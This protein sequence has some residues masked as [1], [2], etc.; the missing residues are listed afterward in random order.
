MKYRICIILLLVLAGSTAP[1]LAA[2]EFRYSYITV[3]RMSIDLIKDD[4]YIRVD[5]TLDTPIKVLI[6]L[7]GTNDLKTKLTRMIN[8]EKITPLEVEMD[9]ARFSVEGEVIDYGDGAMW[10]PEH[11]FNAVTPLLSI[12]TPQGTVVYTDTS[13]LPKGTG[14][15]RAIS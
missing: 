7:L 6:Y 9:H 11:R 8:Y 10:L 1:V 15:F 12:N 2:N 5:Y 3:D 4:M 14:Y 13:E